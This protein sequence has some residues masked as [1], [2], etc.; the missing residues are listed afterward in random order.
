V[1]IVE[2]TDFRVDAVKMTF[3]IIGVYGGLGVDDLVRGVSGDGG[4]ETQGLPS[5]EVA[6]RGQNQLRYCNYTKL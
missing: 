5:V 1:R 2:T 4:H 3:V 6:R